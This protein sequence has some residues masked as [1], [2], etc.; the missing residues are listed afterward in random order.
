MESKIWHKQ[1]YLQTRDRLTATEDS[2]VVAEG[3]GEAVGW[4]GS[5]GLVDANYD[6][7]MDKQ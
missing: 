6:V 7:A 4:T 3:E 1:T 2:L 5:W